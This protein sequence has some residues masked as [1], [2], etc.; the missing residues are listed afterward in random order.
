[1]RLRIPVAEVLQIIRPGAAYTMSG[2]FYETGDVN[3]QDGATQLPTDDEFSA[4]ELTT[5]KAKAFAV[6]RAQTSTSIYARWPSYV[7]ANAALGIYDSL[8]TTDSRFPA[9][10]KAGIVAASAACDQAIADITALTDVAAIQAYQAVI[11]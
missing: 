5:V 1:M 6:V 11:P 10:V 7:Q 3:W 9:N 8:P 2:D 4:G